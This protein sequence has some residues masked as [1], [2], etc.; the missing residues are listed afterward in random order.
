[1]KKSY[2]DRPRESQESPGPGF[3]LLDIVFPFLIPVKGVVWIGN[4]LKDMADTEITD[5]SKVHEELLNL[6]MRFEMGEIEEEEYNRE[7][8]GLLE[9]LEAIRKYE[10]GR[11]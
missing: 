10:E 6:Q 8:T 2:P 1:M 9:R 3:G 4:K 11:K 7:E 5:K